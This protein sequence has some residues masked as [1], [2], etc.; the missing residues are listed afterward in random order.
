M[1]I[2]NFVFLAGLCLVSCGRTVR[3]ESEPRVL[4]T[5]KSDLRPAVTP[6]VLPHAEGMELVFR[7]EF[8]G[9][10]LD[11]QVWISKQYE[12]DPIKNGTLRGPDNLQVKDGY[13]LLHVRKEVRERKGKKSSWTAAFVYTRENI[14]NNIY[15][16]TRFKPTQA[17]GVNNAFWLAG[18][19]GDRKSYC[20]RYEIDCPETRL[21]I[22]AGTN[23]G[24]AHLAWHDWKTQSYIKDAKDK[25][26]H[27]AQGI[28][29]Q[30]GWDEFNTWGVWIGEDE[31]IYYLNGKE[32]WNG[33]THEKYDGQWLSGVGKF[34]RWFPNEEKRAYGKFGQNHWRYNGGYAGDRMNL[35]LATMPWDAD[36]SPLGDAASGTSMVV[37]YVRMFKPAR[38]LKKSPVQEVKMSMADKKLLL[39]GEHSSSGL[40]IEL[41]RGAS[42]SWPL[43]PAVSSKGVY[44]T[45]LGIVIQKNGSGAVD[46]S[47]L[48]KKG[49]P[50]IRFGVDSSNALYGG[51]KMLANTANA[52]PSSDAGGP[53][54]LEGKRYLLVVRLTPGRDGSSHA[55]SMCAYD[56][57]NGGPPTHEP[58]F[59][60][61]IDE[62][63][64][65]SINNGWQINQRDPAASES[66]ATKMSV[67]YEGMG[68]VLIEKF[69]MGESF[70]SVL[71]N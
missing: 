64:N 58:Y 49:V 68:M 50:C 32:V 13:L 18:I 7:D 22:K 62:N 39:N 16:E 54:F 27:I 11:P 5:S 38:T 30:H 8:D 70:L 40:G 57:A 66:V 63:G 3:G 2:L 69:R 9:D 31:F 60:S 52:Y 55:V 10:H 34:D 14:D 61:N 4:E 44:P 65:T 1:K 53:F 20:D 46:F 41:G 17:S 19:T 36:W 51:G 23:T 56:L 37:D 12:D 33:K 28:H 47:L 42:A 29:V 48:D 43:D 21:D 6:A 71:Q 25:D 67:T 24:R 59:H 35:I 45:Y 26:G 15:I